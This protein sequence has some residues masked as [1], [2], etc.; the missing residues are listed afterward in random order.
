VY[1]VTKL[2]IN[3]L[4][5]FALCFNVSQQA[6]CQERAGT[7]GIGVQLS[8][9]PPFVYNLNYIF[10]AADFYGP[11][12]AAPAQGSM[13]MP[14][15]VIISTWITDRIA[16][17]PSI[18]LM[19]YTNETQWRLGLTILNHF[20]DEK[21]QP[22]VLAQTKVYLTSSGSNLVYNN[23]ATRMT[24][25]VFGLGVGGEYFVGKKFSVSGE[26]QLNYLIPDKSGAVYQTDNTLSTGVGV[27]CRFYLN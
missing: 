13:E 9:P 7:I 10:G 26:C 3:A 24:N 22:F 12:V 2:I 1:S 6:L 18:G 21:L 25:Y 4:V 15:D 17:E 8:T 23:S 20:G 19:A 14:P 27:S 5:L 11:Y 16:I